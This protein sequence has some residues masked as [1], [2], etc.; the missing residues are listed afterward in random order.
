MGLLDQVIGEMLGPQAG[1]GS[2]NSAIADA[3][4][5]LLAP[6]QQRPS[7]GADDRSVGTSEPQNRGQTTGGLGD[8]LDSFTRSGQG[9]LADSWVGT[10]QNRPLTPQQLEQALDR[11]TIENLSRRTGLSRDEL[12]RQLS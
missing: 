9:D 6:R 11:N 5:E 12:L 3:L 2:G 8:L 1:S 10:G 4:T 7:A